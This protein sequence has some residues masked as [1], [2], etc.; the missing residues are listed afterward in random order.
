LKAGRPCH[1][2]QH[3]LTMFH[4]F[5]GRGGVFESRYRCYSVACI[6]KPHLENGDKVILP[7]SALDRLASLQ[8]DYPMLF[9]VGNEKAGRQSH[10]GVLEF[11]AEEGVMYMPHWMQQNLLLGE[12]DL[13][14]LKSATLA[15]GTYVK[16][17]P[18]TKDFLDISNPRA[19]LETTL[20][21]YS[22]MTVGD[23]FMVNYNNK[24][25]YI[26]VEEAKPANAIS[27]IE[28]DC[29]VDFAPP[30][31]YTEPAPVFAPPQPAAPA[32][33]VLGRPTSKNS[34]PEPEPEPSAPKFL[35]FSGSGSRLDG[36][37]STSVPQTASTSSL[38]SASS[39]GSLPAQANN[40]GGIAGKVVFGTQL[41]KPGDVIVKKKKNKQEE[42]QPESPKFVAFQGTGNKLK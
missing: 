29:E 26:D 33:P 42:L 25:Y 23:S 18:H 31:D 39:S 4:R 37:A 7:P 6:D 35:A 5:H 11:I 17:R 3:T 32:A 15:K 13:V 40:P 36:K 30:L 16:L 2:L 9:E 14:K 20:R 1:S 27:I 38:A 41:R 21:N 8:I 22:C 24:R 19:V 28:T 34:V 10:C 12:G